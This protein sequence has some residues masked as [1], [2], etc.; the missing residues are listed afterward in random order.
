MGI[1]PAKLLSAFSSTFAL[2]I[3]L[4]AI[5]HSS[6][7]LAQSSTTTTT[8]A[9]STPTNTTPHKSQKLSPEQRQQIKSLIE[10]R[11]SKIAAVLDQNQ[12]SQFNQAINSRKKLKQ[13]LQGLNLNQTQQQ[14]I[15]SIMT[16]YR[17]KMKAVINQ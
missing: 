11:N 10:E 5:V 13:A 9:A 12:A 14:Q 16:T 17:G 15:K 4:P 1:N 2:I 8:P 6:P 7:V 3:I